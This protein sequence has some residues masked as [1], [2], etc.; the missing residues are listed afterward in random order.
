[1]K[2]L[3]LS[4]LCSLTVSLAFGQ[5]KV[6]F[7]PATFTAE[8]EVTITLD[9]TGISALA[10]QTSLYIWAFSND[11]VGGGK[12]A[13]VNGEWGSSSEAAK[14]TMVSANI[15]QYK[16]TG[17]T[18][19]GQSPAELIN[20]GFLAKTK[21][22]SKQ[23]PDFKPYK[24]DP[25]VFTPSQFRLFP[26]KIDYSDMAT[27]YFHQD[28]ATDVNLQ[29]MYN[30]KVNLVFYN[31][32]GNAV[33]GSKAAIVAKKE[34]NVL[35]SYSFIPERVITIPAGTKLGKFSYQF[36]GNVKDANGADVAASGPVTEVVYT[37]FN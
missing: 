37:V 15:F 16:F 20:F 31:E 17:T 12:N 28:L 32:A 21:D 10:G 14:M 5:G 4:I 24:F 7:S 9:I 25:L 11:G 34:S 23:S 19:F 8:D 1:M 22:G 29:R 13:L 30:V 26:A 6:T 36:V 27:I 3:V 33:V 2:K 35:Y 18:F